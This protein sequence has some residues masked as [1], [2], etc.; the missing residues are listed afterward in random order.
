V[1]A[2]EALDRVAVLAGRGNL[3]VT[4]RYTRPGVQ[5]LERAVEKIAWE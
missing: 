3:N 2:G 4:A 1:D 5:D